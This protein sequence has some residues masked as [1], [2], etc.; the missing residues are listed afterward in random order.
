MM[1]SSAS[2]SPRG[3]RSTSI[4]LVV[5]RSFLLWA[6]DTYSRYIPQANNNRKRASRSV[7][8]SYGVVYSGFSFEEVAHG[9]T[10]S[11]I[12]IIHWIHN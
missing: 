4:I 3:H 1:S 10:L 7:S 2:P 8:E 12:N 9:F 6:P 5:E 11:L